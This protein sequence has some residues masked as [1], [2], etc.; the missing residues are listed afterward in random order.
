M[1]ST[2]ERQKERDTVLS[3]FDADIQLLNHA[4]ETR[5]LP[6]AQDAFDSAGALLTTIKVR[7][8]LFR[9]DGLQAQV[10]AG[11]HGRRTGLRG[12]WAVLRR[13]M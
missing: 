4:K 7:S 12:P 5:D 8:L 2:P 11:R 13:C 1:A 3:T 10:Y 6:Q 9:R